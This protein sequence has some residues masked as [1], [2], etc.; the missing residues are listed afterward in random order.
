MPII[1]VYLIC[2]ADIIIR[3]PLEVI[4]FKELLSMAWEE[5]EDPCTT[6]L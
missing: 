6:I 3:L 1:V 2:F 5:I 4:E